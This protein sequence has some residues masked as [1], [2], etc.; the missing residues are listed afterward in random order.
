MRTIR[1]GKRRGSQKNKGQVLTIWLAVMIVSIAV[2]GATGV[3]QV[4]E[5]PWQVVF[6]AIVAALFYAYQGLA[7]GASREHSAPKGGRRRTINR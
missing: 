5:A 1:N 4:V 6:P 7:A 2:A 3:C